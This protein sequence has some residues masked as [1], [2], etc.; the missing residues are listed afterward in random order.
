MNSFIV[1]PTTKKGGFMSLSRFF[2]VTL[3]ISSIGCARWGVSPSY[4]PVGS[5]SGSNSKKIYIGKIQSTLVSKES[6]VN[7]LGF[8][9][10]PEPFLKKDIGRYLAEAIKK[11]GEETHFFTPAMSSAAAD[12]D[13]SGKVEE[14]SYTMKVEEVPMKGEGYAYFYSAEFYL[15]FHSIV[16]QNGTIILEKV[17]PASK[18]HATV[19]N[20]L[21]NWEI[22][23]TEDLNLLIFEIVDEVFRDIEKKL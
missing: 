12:Y 19:Y 21:T 3:L 15:T 1:L 2:L 7:I 6:D 23:F 11:E 4:E 17:Y 10:A 16:K 13:I 8:T 22:P 18:R 14:F 5:L 20:T 9:I